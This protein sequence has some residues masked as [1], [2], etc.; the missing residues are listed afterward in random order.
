MQKKRTRI[1]TRGQQWLQRTLTIQAFSNGHVI[2][3]KRK[4]YNNFI[5]SVDTKLHYDVNVYHRNF[6]WVFYPFS[7]FNRVNIGKT[8]LN[9]QINGSA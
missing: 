1:M 6:T 2:P 5:I 7:L 8:H 3:L 4:Y 9:N